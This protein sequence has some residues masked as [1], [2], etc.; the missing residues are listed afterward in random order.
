MGR[1][2]AGAWLGLGLFLRR[3]GIVGLP[4]VSHLLGALGASVVGC[5]QVGDGGVASFD[6]A[7]GRVREVPSLGDLEL[8]EEACSC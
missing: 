1:S 7:R 4:R 5:G 8:V 2:R 6:W 3:P